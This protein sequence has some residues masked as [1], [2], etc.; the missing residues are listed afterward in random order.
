MA[1]ASTRG[2]IPS[3]DCGPQLKEMH[4]C[5]NIGAMTILPDI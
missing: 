3:A 1:P 5:L 2:S 4:I